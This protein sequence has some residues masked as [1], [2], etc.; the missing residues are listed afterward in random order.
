MIRL[1]GE[2]ICTTEEEAALVLTYLPDHLRL[3]RAE[4][5]CLSFEVTPTADPMVWK[6]EECFC[7]RAAF[8]A[9]QKRTRTS[10]WFERTGHI[11]RSYRF[12]DA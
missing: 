2:L 4:P 5:G 6:V 9:H 10:L 7:S 1:S 11:R 8:D 3:T 12:L